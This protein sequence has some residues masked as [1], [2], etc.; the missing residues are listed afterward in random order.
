MWL[1]LMSLLSNGW[2]KW[3]RKK[4]A[5]PQPF[6]LRSLQLFLSMFNPKILTSVYTSPSHFFFDGYLTNIVIICIEI[7][8]GAAQLKGQFVC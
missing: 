6:V 4:K 1:V 5:K 2:F 8:K 3:K 7:L